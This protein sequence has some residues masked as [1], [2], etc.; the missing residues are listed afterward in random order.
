MPTGSVFYVY[1][2]FFI[3]CFYML[4]WLSRQWFAIF[5]I[6]QYS[7]SFGLLSKFV[8]IQQTHVWSGFNQPSHCSPKSYIS[9]NSYVVFC[10]A[11]PSPIGICTNLSRGR[12]GSTLPTLVPN[13]IKYQNTCFAIQAL[14]CSKLDQMWDGSML[15]SQKWFS[16][17]GMV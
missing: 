17:S 15:G 16:K 11:H 12:D 14:L 7:S 10:N 6:P 3:Y 13:L 1:G 5:A 9:F 8:F 4:Y 2:P